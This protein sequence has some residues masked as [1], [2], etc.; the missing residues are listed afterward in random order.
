VVKQI[1]MIMMMAEAMVMI[2]CSSLEKKKEENKKAQGKGIFDRSFLFWHSRHQVGL[3][4]FR[5]DSRTIKRG[6][7]HRE[8]LIKVPLDVL[9][10][11]MC[12]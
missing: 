3:S 5:I 8:M 1:V 7:T 2:K 4:V 10:H 6:E 11:C 9:I 12:I